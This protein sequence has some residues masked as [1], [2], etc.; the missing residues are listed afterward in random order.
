MESQLVNYEMC[1]TIT[2]DF[3]KQQCLAWKCLDPSIFER[4]DAF[5]VISFDLLPEGTQQ[6]GL[7]MMVEICGDSNT[8]NMHNGLNDYSNIN[9][10]L[11]LDRSTIFTGFDGTARFMGVIDWIMHDVYQIPTPYIS[12]SNSDGQ[13]VPM[14]DTERLIRGLCDDTETTSRIPWSVEEH[15]LTGSLCFSIS[16]CEVPKKMNLMM[17]DRQT[18][19]KTYLLQLVSMIGP[20]LGLRLSPRAFKLTEEDLLR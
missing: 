12:L 18:T 16:T 11:T 14:K 17:R 6:S 15:P 2:E 7:R 10:N 9:E 5:R 13:S 20:A 8:D 1:G 19:N 3:F 4:R